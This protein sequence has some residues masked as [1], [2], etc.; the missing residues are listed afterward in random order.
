MII[1]QVDVVGTA[2]PL[3][4]EDTPFSSDSLVIASSSNSRREIGDRNGVA[5]HSTPRHDAA[6]L[7][8]DTRKTV[9]QHV[10]YGLFA[11]ALRR[12]ATVC[13]G[14]IFTVSYAGWVL[15]L[16]HSSFGMR[17]QSA[18]WTALRR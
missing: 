6:R 16:D 11:E 5:P 1:D 8:L 12:Y 9:L 14:Q 10:G 3:V 2:I 13:T 4:E 18:V 7:R 15:P 17:C